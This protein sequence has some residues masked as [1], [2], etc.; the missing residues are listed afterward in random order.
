M[1]VI[2]KETYEIRL[3]VWETRDVPLVDGDKVD[4]WVRVNFDPTGNPEDMVEKRTDV[5]NGSKTG[6]G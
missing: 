3:I 5:H 1:N 6:W 4:I 2:K